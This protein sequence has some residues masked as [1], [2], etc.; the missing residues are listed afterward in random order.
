MSTLLRLTNDLTETVEFLVLGD[1][2]S[3]ESLLL[4][5]AA[6]SRGLGDLQSDV[7][8]DT[9]SYREEAYLADPQED[10][11]HLDNE[12]ARHLIYADFYRAASL[13]SYAC[14]IGRPE[15]K[16]PVITRDSDVAG[17][18]GAVILLPP[19]G[20]LRQYLVDKENIVPGEKDYQVNLFLIGEGSEVSEDQEPIRKTL[21]LFKEQTTQKPIYPKL[22]VLNPEIGENDQNGDNH[23]P[24]DS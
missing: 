14:E 24:T 9:Q 7:L 22:C 4:A 1:G 11:E 8:E 10:I 20:G 3:C 13:S 19:E 23:E 16:I 18:E 6:R 15:D 2:S 12:S 21:L 5:R 17:D